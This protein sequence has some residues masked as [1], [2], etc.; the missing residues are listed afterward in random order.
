[1]T[2]TVNDYMVSVTCVSASVWQSPT[3]ECVCVCVLDELTLTSH[4]VQRAPAS[5]LG[6]PWNPHHY[7]LHT[8]NSNTHA[9]SYTRDTIEIGRHGLVRS[10]MQCIGA[11][12][13]WWWWWWWIDDLSPVQ[14]AVAVITGI[15]YYIIL[16]CTQIEI[17]HYLISN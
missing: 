2:S 8:V 14:S 5:S 7:S 10:P 1:M 4:R 15:M 9:R 3:V 16:Y 11:D 13:W 12:Y 17:E 6:S